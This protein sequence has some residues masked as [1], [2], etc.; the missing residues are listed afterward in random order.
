MGDVGP[1]SGLL[2]LDDRSAGGWATGATRGDIWERV[3]PRC[4]DLIEDAEPE[5]EPRTPA[6]PCFL[7]Y[8][9]SDRR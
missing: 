2:G 6:G 9:L 4:L 7:V 5:P 8:R 3:A 1:D